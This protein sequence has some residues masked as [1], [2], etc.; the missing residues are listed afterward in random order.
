MDKR[1]TIYKLQDLK[2]CVFLSLINMLFGGLL[3]AVLKGFR[4]L[5]FDKIEESLLI[6]VDLEQNSIGLKDLVGDSVFLFHSTA[7]ETL[8]L[9]TISLISILF[10][11]RLNGGVLI[12][13]IVAW[14]ITIG[15]SLINFASIMIALRFMTTASHTFANQGYNVVTIF[16]VIIFLIGLSLLFFKSLKDLIQTNPRK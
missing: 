2:G 15:I 13:R 5:L 9:S 14:T 1:R 8:V 16:G 4:V 12:R 10:L 11:I 7:I 3:L 6:G